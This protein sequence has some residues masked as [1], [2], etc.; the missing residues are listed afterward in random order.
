M[1]GL[2]ARAVD[3]ENGTWA[4]VGLNAGQLNQQC[5]RYGY[6][7]EFYGGSTTAGDHGLITI[8]ILYSGISG[9]ELGDN[10]TAIASL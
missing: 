8:A 2:T 9:G 1:I 4:A 3:G 6:L 5:V 7:K 10:E